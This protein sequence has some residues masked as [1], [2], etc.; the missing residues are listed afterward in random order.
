MK[1]QIPWLRILVEGVVIVCS[2][3]LA[4]GIDALWES[5]GER[6]AEDRLLSSLAVEFRVNKDRL[7][8]NLRFSA[9]IEA[10]AIAA[11]E[12]AAEPTIDVSPDS[13]D[14]LLLN[15]SW[16]QPTQWVTGTVDAVVLGGDLVL[17]ESQQLRSEL[18][19]WRQALD[20]VKVA[21]DVAMQ[22]VNERWF[23]FLTTHTYLPQVSNAVD[24]RPGDD[25][26]YPAAMLPTGEERFDHR[27]LLQTRELQNL[28]VM[29]QWNHQDLRIWYKDFESDMD[30]VLA[31][32]EAELSR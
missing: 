3:L 9:D 21:E 31:T 13:V 23:P 14:H 29:H 10:A 11:L 26:A 2:I 5:R 25:D 1:K 24:R 15:V 16:A 30:R 4:F 22:F 6:I 27:P 17:I 12:L 32:I 18:T 20:L 28:L 19:A 8:G 7:R